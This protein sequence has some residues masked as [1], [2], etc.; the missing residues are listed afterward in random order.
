MNYYHT[1][2]FIT[3]LVALSFPVLF[4]LKTNRL[5]SFGVIFPFF[6]FIYSFI[7]PLAMI[8]PIEVGDISR[9]FYVWDEMF[10]ISD[11]SY[12]YIAHTYYLLFYAAWAAA[13]LY[14]TTPLKRTFSRDP[15][16]PEKQYYSTI[17]KSFRLNTAIFIIC[18]FSLFF[19]WMLLNKFGS[20]INAGMTIYAAKTT[21]DEEYQ[22]G[23]IMGG[24][25]SL[26]GGLLISTAAIL[27]AKLR[28]KSCSK[29]AVLV[30]IACFVVYLVT[31]FML[32]D[33]SQL[34]IPMIGTVVLYG[35]IWRNIRL[36]RATIGLAIPFLVLNFLIRTMR[37]DFAGEGLAY[38]SEEQV[39][40]TMEIL[41]T[42]F[43]SVESF[44]AYAALPFMV[45][46]GT[47]LLLGYSFYELM[48]SFIPRFMAPFRSL[49]TVP[50]VMYA[51]AAGFWGSLRGY[52]MHHVSDW[53]FNFGVVGVL[54]GGLMIGFLMGKVEKKG[55]QL[56]SPFWIVAFAMLC[57]ALPS[58]LRSPIPGIRTIFY[59]YWS[60]PFLFFFI[61]PHL[62]TVYRKI[63]INASEQC[64]RSK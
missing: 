53:Y 30:F 62:K 17:N 34:I 41:A 54:V 64:I 10:A 24:M 11:R 8:Y 28:Q 49:V 48:I 19:W 63:F 61:I 57:G 42:A 5:M 18:V 60:I 9:A 32:G 13:F 15:A 22:I 51:K 45:A 20:A 31:G 59:E 36:S 55:Y 1:Y 14:A 25:F 35:V 43:L 21:R 2:Y 38:L 40:I 39:S 26:W 16:V 4:Y 6:Y 33:R 46:Y 50:Y 12:I 27:F 29:I 56:K 7:G 58:L 3:L 47:P 37:K 23:T 44:A 52:T